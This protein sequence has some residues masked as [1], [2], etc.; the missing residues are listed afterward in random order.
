MYRTDYSEYG[1]I[2]FEK[3]R[4]RRVKP[5]VTL[6]D[7]LDCYVDLPETDYTDYDFNKELILDE[8]IEFEVMDIPEIIL[9]DL[10][11]VRFDNMGFQTHTELV[12]LTGDG[13]YLIESIEPIFV[14]EKK[15]VVEYA[16]QNDDRRYLEVPEGYSDVPISLKHNEMYH[17]GIITQCD[18]DICQVVECPVTDIHKISRLPN[19]SGVKINFHDRSMRVLKDRIVPLMYTAF[20]FVDSE[21]S[22]VMPDTTI[23]T[24]GPR[25]SRNVLK[26]CQSYNVRLFDGFAFEPVKHT[27]TPEEVYAAKIRPV[28][29]DFVDLFE[30]YRS[31][32]AS[33]HL[34]VYPG[35]RYFTTI[36]RSQRSALTRMRHGWILRGGFKGDDDELDAERLFSLFAKGKTIND[37]ERE[38]RMLGCSV[39]FNFFRRMVAMHCYVQKGVIKRVKD[40]LSFLM[41]KYIANIP[42]GLAL[43]C[44]GSMSPDVISMF[45][46]REEIKEVMAAETE[47]EREFE[48]GDLVVAV[49]K[50]CHA[51]GAPVIMQQ[52]ND[53]PEM[54][55]VFQKFRKRLFDAGTMS[56]KDVLEKYYYE[57]LTECIAF[58]T[59]IDPPDI[60]I[61][62]AI[63]WLHK[64]HI[65][66]MDYIWMLNRFSECD[67]ISLN[68]ITGDYLRLRLNWNTML[69]E[70]VESTISKFA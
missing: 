5:S 70:I 40:R 19:L 10:D 42:T 67:A 45:H 65:L 64:M 54:R 66:R 52:L 9:E 43:S 37:L 35:S 1:N 50:S 57:T 6:R 31:Y 24:R 69:Y 17:S 56:R 47:I 27:A 60:M 51:Y 61:M 18:T 3:K 12:V 48:I 8:K 39:D 13:D 2:D 33:T 44:V 15:L 28:F 49:A 4:V 41:E 25:K 14:G 7:D 34:T 21:G 59:K 26:M 23:G 29:Q 11:E 53:M 62:G 46:V 36:P 68:R 38:V 16:S 22:L 20:G 63:T 30:P 55:H 32:I 58:S